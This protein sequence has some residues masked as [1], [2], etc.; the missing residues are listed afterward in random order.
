MRLR[1]VKIYT[2]HIYIA[3][4][5]KWLNLVRELRKLPHLLDIV[6]APLS[7]LV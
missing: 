7:D 6:K 3:T 1:P 4:T 2:V 5:V